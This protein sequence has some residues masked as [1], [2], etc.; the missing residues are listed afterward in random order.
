LSRWHDND[1]VAIKTKLPRGRAAAV[2]DY[3]ENYSHE[4]RFEHQSKYFSQVQTTI[5]PVV[6]MFRVEDLE[7]ID[8]AEKEQM[9]ALF[10][11]YDLPSVISETHYVISSDMQHDN[12]MIQKLLDDFILPYIQKVAPTVEHV[13]VRSD[14]CKAQFKCANNFYWVS[15][16]KA[17]GCGLTIHWSFFE[18]C[19][20]KCYCDPEGGTLKNAASRH[21]LNITDQADQLKNSEAFYNWA[22][23]KRCLATPKKTL[24]EKK[25]K[26]IY[27]RFFYWVPSKGTGAVDRSN[28]VKYKAEG[29]PSSVEIKTNR[30]ATPVTY[31][32][33]PSLPLGTSILHEFNDICKVG[34]VSTRRA[35]C[36]Q[37][38]ACWADDRRNCENKDYVGP[39]TEMFIGRVT[40]PAAAVE[41]MERAAI[42]DAAFARAE[43]ARPRTT[44]ARTAP[45]PAP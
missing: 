41:R 19:P 23:G 29:A 45:T 1:F 5:V 25:G 6:L 34:T 32:T 4:P 27:R 7:N 40:V 10:A 24:Q 3:A 21:E 20:G 38:N 14:G 8:A 35:A 13:H 43:K 44:D 30:A 28:V 37:C 16:Q 39:P 15:R 17:E 31:A 36:H 9:L 33:A 42:R 26:G 11:K 2:I 18:S 22:R 12:A